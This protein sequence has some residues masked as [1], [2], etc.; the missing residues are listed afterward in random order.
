M[1]SSADPSSRAEESELRCAIQEAVKQLS[2][3]SRVVTLL[4]YYEDLSL[5]EIAQALNLSLAAVKSRLFQGRKQLQEQ[6]RKLY[7]EFSPRLTSRQRRK[8]MAYVNM[9]LVQVLPVEERL[10]V[11]LLDPLSQRILTLWLHPLEGRTLAILKGVVKVD[12]PK[13]SFEPSAYLDFV[14]DLFQATGATV[15]AVRLEEF[16][17]RVFYA[18]VLVQSL[19]GPQQVKA[20]PGEGLALAVRANAP[21]QVEGA[22]LARWGV[23]L[24]PAKGRTEEERLQEAVT[25]VIANARPPAAPKL[26]R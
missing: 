8:T 4:F 9:N 6:L 21:L 2:E 15:Q 20:R 12:I 14:S 5:E 16:Q 1:A 24:P 11:V 18:Q 25:A 3:K 17:E 19:N 7:P 23:A 26:R 10:L 13:G 22:V